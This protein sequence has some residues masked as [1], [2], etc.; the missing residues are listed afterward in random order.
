MKLVYLTFG[1]VLLSLIFWVIESLWP[2]I[3]AQQ[4]WRRGLSTDLVYW[5]FT[6]VVTR[7][8][9]LLALLIALAPVLLLLG[10]RLEE[11][12][13]RNAIYNGR[14]PALLWPYWLQGMLVFAGGD[15]IE[16]WSHRWFHGRGL[17]RF[18]AIH[19]SSKEVDW[20][21]SVR[22]HPVN[23][24]GSRFCRTIVLVLLGISPTVLAAYV[25]FSTVYALFLHANVPWTFGPLR[26]V[27]ASPVFHRW[28]HA[29]E[30]G[31][32]DKNFAGFLPVYDLLFGTFYMPPGRQPTEFGVQDDS[33]PESFLGQMLYPFERVS[34]IS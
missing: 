30:A 15:F 4:K 26:Y 11:E 33:V 21:S 1:F 2:G 18:H 29:S 12:V 5:F 6:P 14:P 10:Y 3:P 7:A 8:I 9:S 31:A 34:R 28:H 24:L 20:L 25:T 27:V 17:W 16:Y 23:E 32:I 19:H 13:F 22:L